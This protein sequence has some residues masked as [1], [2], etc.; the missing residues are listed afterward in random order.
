M[1]KYIGILAF[2]LFSIGLFAQSKKERIEKIKIDGQVLTMLI[3]ETNDTIFI[4]D[5]DDVSVSSPRKFANQ[6]EYRLYLKYRRYANKVYPY[7]QKAIRI[8]RESEQITK[9]LSR[10]KRKRH[11]KRLQKEME[12]EFEEPLKHLTRLQGK[13]LIKM[14]EKELDTPF[15]TLLKNLRG[16]F[17]AMKWSTFGYMYGYRL[18]HGYRKGD[19]P[20]LDAVL[21][22]Y[23][24]SFEVE[25]N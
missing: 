24:V 7:A 13:I 18:K 10:R 23:D 8:F 22:D 16:T 15:Y 11:F 6:Q 12:D 2:F 4:A 3:T 1:Y 9:D 25:E 17:T 19:D 21:E 20:I 5:L 14:I